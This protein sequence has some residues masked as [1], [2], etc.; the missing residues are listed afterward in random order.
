MKILCKPEGRDEIYLPDKASLIA[1][2]KEQ[3][4]TEIHNI[5][6]GGM[7]KIGADHSMESVIQDIEDSDRIAILIGEARKKNLEHSLAIITDNKLEVYDLG[8]IT[9]DDI[10]LE[11]A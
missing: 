7:V 9:M 6:D 1:W 3:N 8:E 2:I 5:M 4:F 11:M 10:E